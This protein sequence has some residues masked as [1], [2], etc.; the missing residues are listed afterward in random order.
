MSS[1]YLHKADF[2]WY[3]KIVMGIYVY[4]GLHKFSKLRCTSWRERNMDEFSPEMSSITQ[5]RPGTSEDSDLNDVQ[6]IPCN[7]DFRDETCSRRGDGA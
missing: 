5:K 6:L 4:S 7:E 3:G 2:G 1:F